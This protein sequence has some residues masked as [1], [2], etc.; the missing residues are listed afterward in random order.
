MESTWC[1]GQAKR[2][3]DQSLPSFG[4]AQ[5]RIVGNQMRDRVLCHE[6]RYR[7]RRIAQQ[8]EDWNV[9]LFEMELNVLEAFEHEAK[10]AF[11]GAQEIRQHVEH[12]HQRLVRLACQF[13]CV[14]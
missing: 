6:R 7:A 3:A 4:D 12:Y 2:I 9:E 14:Q 10:V 11:G 5:R 1:I 13:L 8:Q